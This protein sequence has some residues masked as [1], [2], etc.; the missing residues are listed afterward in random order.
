MK[1]YIKVVVKDKDGN[2]V[3]DRIEKMHSLTQNFLAL[4]FM[5][6]AGTTDFNASSWVSYKLIQD[7]LRLPSKLNTP[8][9]DS[10]VN[11]IIYGNLSLIN[12]YYT[13]ALGTGSQAFSPTLQ[14]LANQISDCDTNSGVLSCSDAIVNIPIDTTY[15]ASNGAT[16]NILKGNSMSISQSAV[17]TSN[18]NLSITEYGVL[19]KLVISYY[20]YTNTIGD[21]I[22]S[23][24]YPRLIS[25]DTFSSPLNIPAYGSANIQVNISFT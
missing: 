16:Y 14:S 7:V 11:N 12:W 8:I 24:V 4:I 17:N 1:N 22:R 20:Y 5:L 6:V 10:S 9:Y 25:Y 18:N 3:D 23:L 2:I 13:I 19:A 15:A 21:Y